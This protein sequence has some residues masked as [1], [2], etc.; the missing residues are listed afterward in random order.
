[1]YPY[2]F[3]TTTSL[4]N[5]STIWLILLGA[6]ALL[7]IFYYFLGKKFGIREGADTNSPGG[8]TIMEYSEPRSGANAL[9]NKINKLPPSMLS[10]NNNPLSMT[11]P[12]AKF[13]SKVGSKVSNTLTN[14][15]NNIKEINENLELIKQNTYDMNQAL[16]AI[17]LD[18]PRV[19]PRRNKKNK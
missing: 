7:I 8:H 19:K 10:V 12:I 11:N 15:D 13:E 3:S 16:L 6:G 9:K 18:N 5:K 4:S 2:T 1:M 14:F 17:L